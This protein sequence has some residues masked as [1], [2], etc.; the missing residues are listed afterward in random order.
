MLRPS[1]RYVLADREE[2]EGFIEKITRKIE[3]IRDN[4]TLLFFDESTVKQH[5]RLASTWS[6]K[7]IKRPVNTFGNHAKVC[8]FGA[9]E[10]LKGMMFHMKFKNLQAPNFVRFL[11]HIRARRKGMKVI[12]VLDGSQTHTA[13]KV[14]EFLEENAGWLEVIWM[15]GYS[16]DLNP[17]E[18][19]WSYMKSIVSSNYMFTKLKDMA[20][21][22]TDFF[23]R[24]RYS[25]GK[26]MS[27]CSVN[28]L[29]GKL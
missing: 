19:F 25:K 22:I 23:N 10:P 9:V 3:G 16:P 8:V 15:P 21:A 1:H 17:I 2:R 27:I 11:K 14:K 4:E 7:G 6:L 29:F 28:Y 24:I 13:D 12:A 18:H 26:I 20:N 5:P